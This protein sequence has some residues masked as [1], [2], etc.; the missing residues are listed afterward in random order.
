MALS[1]L[2]F[3]SERDAAASEDSA[4]D[5]HQRFSAVLPGRR[6][7]TAAIADEYSQVSRPPTHQ[8]LPNA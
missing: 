5:A 6:G 4:V 8:F 7:E 3:I 2:K 1:S